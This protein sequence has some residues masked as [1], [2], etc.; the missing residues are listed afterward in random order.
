MAN[1]SNIARPYAQ[2]LF[3]LAQEQ[4]DLSAWSDQ[5]ELLSAIASDDTTRE[6]IN[7]PHIDSSQ[8]TQ[9]FDSVAGDRINDSG[10][11]LVR[12][13][14]KNSR[15]EVLPEIAQAYAERRAEAES[16]VEAEMITASEIGADQQQQFVDVLQKKL[17]RTVQLE[18]GVD[19]E[20]IGGAIIRAGDWVIDG[21]V[22]A[23]LEQLVGAIGS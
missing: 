20:L 3:E 1:Q 5:L 10:K 23:Q 13:L 4:N 12:L 19:E 8:I 2:A 16:V 7:N 11:N 9:L 14:V 15:I 17:G 22:K 21:S 6:L 18:F